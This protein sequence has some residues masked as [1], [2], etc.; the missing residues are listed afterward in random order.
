MGDGRYYTYY[1]FMDITIVMILC[2]LSIVSMLFFYY[3]KNKD[4]DINYIF[5]P[6]GL[7]LSFLI[8]RTIES[9][10]P[11]L[12]LASLLRQFGLFLLITAVYLS[13][14]EKDYIE[15]WK[16]VI[17]VMTLIAAMVNSLLNNFIQNYAFHNMDYSVLYKL[18]ILSL[19]M[20]LLIYF[21]KIKKETLIKSI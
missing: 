21:L 9:V 17:V 15:K 20:S 3:R 8:L 4:M 14:G 10:S 2:V 18:V 12:G 16:R 7:N 6:Q 5:L 13:I 11:N 19:L 1:Q